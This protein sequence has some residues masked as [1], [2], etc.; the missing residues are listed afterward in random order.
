M[1]KST[2]SF[3]FFHKDNG[4][5]DEPW[6]A[7]PP[8]PS[9]GSAAA[10][11]RNQRAQPPPR[12]PGRRRGRANAGHQPRAQ[13]VGCMPLLG[14][15]IRHHVGNAMDESVAPRARQRA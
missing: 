8:V 14:V 11:G 12:S 2:S 1:Y 15:A 13:P 3:R 6:P 9:A 7:G 4:A 5:A 10:G